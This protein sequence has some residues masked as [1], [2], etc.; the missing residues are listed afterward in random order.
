LLFDLLHSDDADARAYNADRTRDLSARLANL[1][2]RQHRAGDLHDALV[3]ANRARAAAR[4]LHALRAEPPRIT[5]ADALPVLGAFW[6]LAPARYSSLA[7][8]AAD[9]A[10]RRLPLEGRRVLVAGAPVDAAAMHA[11]IEAEGAIVVAELSPFGYC[12]TSTDV[13]LSDDACAALA[14][15]YGR[16]SIDARLPVDVF[17]RKL[18]DALGAADAVVLS[19]PPHDASF[20]WDYP[21]I[22]EL[23]ARRAIPHIVLTGDP[24]FGVAAADRERIRSLLGSAPSR[25]EAHFG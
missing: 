4:R 1:A 22:R 24:A 18:E 2:G 6:Q 20:G 14:N 5:G 7:N 25:P 15:H 8:A 23:L 9:S 3:S 11:T 17:M 19:L 21:R 12:G 10:A 16:E 13:E